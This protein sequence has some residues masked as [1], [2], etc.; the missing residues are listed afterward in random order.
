MNK[1]DSDLMAI[2]LKEHGYHEAH[3]SDEADVVIYNTCSVRQHAEDRVTA[4]ISSNRHK[5]RERGG[6]I[7]VTG[8]MAQ[9]RGQELLDRRLADL[10]IGPYQ[11]PRIGEILER[12][13]DL[14]KETLYISQS[15][16]DFQ[17]RL[18][19]D[20]LLA[21]QGQPW[22]QWVTI[23][24]GCEN[25]CAYC[26][27][28]FVR[29]KLISFASADILK[30]IQKL[31]TEGIREITLLG[32]N[33]N[34]Y[35]QDLNDLPFY[36]LLASTAGTEGLD[37]VNFLTSHPKDFSEDIVK[38]IADYP[39]ISRNI[40]LPLQSGSNAVL[41]RMN[42]QY[43][44]EHYLG[45]IDSLASHLDIFS[46]S[47][48]LIVGF[49]GETESDFEDTLK[50]VSTIRFDEAFMYAYSPR[51]GTP[52]AALEDLLSQKE[53]VTRLNTLINLQRNISVEK[54]EARVNTIEIMIPEKI[55]KRSAGEVMGRTFLNHP[56]V[57]PGT[58]K[59]IGK[60]VKVQVTG[61]NGS[62]L[63]AHKIP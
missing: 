61:V 5:I 55:S 46:V 37:R 25:F 8:C 13:A 43:S 41:K 53:K 28:P 2:S 52:A 4:R 6:S 39:N 24:H 7:V 27:V 58:E 14:K 3:S 38:V 18:H 48:D 30:H 50:A 29:G 1:S 16:E 59:D 40:H 47:T 42:R 51:S 56:A 23:T 44:M 34:Q 57:I 9:R 36:K 62:T 35:G 26:I 49:P 32:Q 20:I 22:H 63:L 54:L 10:V 21:N 60:I 12:A 15:E 17:E 19:P 33:V 11:S 45:L 31:A